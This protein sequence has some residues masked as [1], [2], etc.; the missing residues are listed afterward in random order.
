MRWEPNRGERGILTVSDRVVPTDENSTVTFLIHTQKEPFV[1]GNKIAIKGEKRELD[2][3]IKSPAEVKI[4]LNGGEGRRFEADGT[5]YLPGVDT[6]EAGWGRI[7]IS[8]RGS[9]TFEIEME[10]RKK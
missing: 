4:T 9:V 1:D 3:R 2:C 8:A 6:S 10:I 7:E 5:D